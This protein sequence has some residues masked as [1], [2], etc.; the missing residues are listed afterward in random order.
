MKKICVFVLLF[1][2]ALSTFADDALVLPK[3]VFRTYITGAFAF[4]TQA[5]DLDGDKQDLDEESIR[6]F[7]LGGA[8]EYGVTDWISAA[9]QWAPGWYLWSSFYEATAADAPLDTATVNGPADIFAGAKIQLIGENAP[10]ANQMFRLAFA[11]GVKIPLPSPDWQ[12][13]AN[14]QAA[15]DPWKIFAA[16]KHT[17]GVGGRAYF[18]YILNEMIYINLFGEFIYFPIAKTY[19]DVG[20]I[21]WATVQ[22][23]KGLGFPY[24]EEYEF[25]FDLTLEAEPHFEMMLT[26]GIRF[27]AGVPVTFFMTPEP[28]VD[29]TAQ[30]DEDTYL[31]TVAPNV[32]LFL[33][34]FPVPLEFKLG[35]TLPLL[36][37]NELAA[38]ILVLQL[39]SYLK[40]W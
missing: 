8:V 1:A 7:N 35:Y 33:M 38:N 12:E 18:D 30:T 26:D 11:P 40:F 32:S 5:F 17:L 2:V 13:E 9:V 21:E 16:D 15:G 19:E 22:T 24:P 39:K 31:L 34:K 29:G 10:V 27:G 20:Y 37:K 23:L 36:G 25:G 4:A 6:I 28:K 14:D 3:G